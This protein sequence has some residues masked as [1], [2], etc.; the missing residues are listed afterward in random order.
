MAWYYL[1]LIWIIGVVL[2]LLFVAG[3]ARKPRPRNL[4]EK[5]HHGGSMDVTNG[6]VD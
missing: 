2:T 5:I 4:D 3:G 1:V 6:E